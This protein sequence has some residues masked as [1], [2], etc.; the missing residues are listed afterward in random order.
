M[1]R[2]IL[3]LSLALAWMACGYG[4]DP[5][6]GANPTT[7]IRVEVENQNFYDATV[8]AITTAGEQR[9]GVVGGNS[10]KM[11]TARLTRP[12]FVHLRIR[13]LGGRSFK[14]DPIDASPGETLVLI[15]P[16]ALGL[17]G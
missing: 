17:I 1:S 14:L 6:Y 16:A 11:F 4:Q 13:M 10:T 12:D 9:L 2:Q 8:Y 15:I 7:T 5:F 3:T